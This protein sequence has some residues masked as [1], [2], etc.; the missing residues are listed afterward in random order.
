[1]SGEIPGLTAAGFLIGSG[2]ALVV[3]LFA[4]RLGIMLGLMDHPDPVGGRKLH[5]RPTPLVGGLAVVAATLAGLLLPGVGSGFEPLWYALIVGG[6][7][8][9][10]LA[11]DRFGLTAPFRFLFAAG[12]LFLAIVRVDDFRIFFLL[13][14]GQERLILMPG[15]LGIGFTL[16]CLLGLLNAVNMADGKNGLV[17][18]QALVWTIVLMVRLP[19]AQLPLLAA[20]A[21][22]LL[23]LL[24]FN[25]RGALFLGDSG[26]YGVSAIFGLLAI[27]AWNSGFADMRAEDI[28]VIFA[29]PV[30]DTLRLIVHRLFAGRTPFTPGRDHLHHYLFARWGWPRPL[31]WVLAL[32]A[33]PN[34]GAIL[35]PGTG[36]FWLG[37]TA[38][39]Y[40][41][42]VAAATHAGPAPTLPGATR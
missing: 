12:L 23:V 38:L 39:G 7:F 42:L 16:V 29:L 34:L 30:F 5:G 17:I 41:G 6:M 15:A 40:L 37:L 27:K 13:F 20:I 18:G 36:L 8:L 2:I 3:G 22:A 10:G 1:M 25:L 14:D 32:V 21:G 31:P 26:S 4:S 11:D 19:S 28:A 9:V 35:I 24:V 33:I